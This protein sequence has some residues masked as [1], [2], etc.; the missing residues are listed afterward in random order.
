MPAP[1]GP[2]IASGHLRFAPV[3]P[4][5]FKPKLLCFPHPERS[6]GSGTKEENRTATERSEI[7]EHSIINIEANIRRWTQITR[8]LCRLPDYPTGLDLNSM[9]TS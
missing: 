6:A 2:G 5:A 7:A 9:Q 1:R 8:E 4:G 3:L